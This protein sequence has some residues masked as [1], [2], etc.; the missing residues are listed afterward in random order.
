MTHSGP[1]IFIHS[2][3]CSHTE[4]RGSP[5]SRRRLA[6]SEEYAALI[7]PARDF[8]GNFT[9][10]PGHPAAPGA[11]CSSG[12]NQD[13][14]ALQAARLHILEI[15]KFHGNRQP[16][17]SLVDMDQIMHIRFVKMAGKRPGTQL[18]PG[19]KNRSPDRQCIH[20]SLFMKGLDQPEII[21]D[22]LHVTAKVRKLF[23]QMEIPAKADPVNLLSEQRT[24]H[25]D[26]V[27]F[28]ITDRIS[29]FTERGGSP[30]S[31]RE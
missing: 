29:P 20:A 4:I 14:H 2:Q 7:D 6:H 3:N 18:P 8:P 1:R 31:H 30:Q 5:R 11:P 17:Q 27:F 24:A 19:M 28:R 23:H 21:R 22:R 26:P 16:G 25:A 9:V 12:V 13:I 15:Y 10:S